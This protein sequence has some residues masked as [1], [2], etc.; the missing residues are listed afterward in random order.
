MKRSKLCNDFLKVGNDAC[1]V[2][3]RKQRNLCVTLLQETKTKKFLKFRTKFYNNNK[4]SWKS[5]K[6][7]FS[8][9]ITVKEIIN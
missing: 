9:K 6:P 1:Q 2:G 8:D 5:V 7:L 3:N 4:R